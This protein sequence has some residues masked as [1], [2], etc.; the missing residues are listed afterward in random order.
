M[1]RYTKQYCRRDCGPVAVLNVLKWCGE[2]V[3]YKK[4]IKNIKSISDY[5][6]R[7]GVDPPY[8]S[9]AIKQV[10]LSYMRIISPKIADIDRHLENNEAL[11]IRFMYDAHRGHYIFCYSKS[12]KYYRVANYFNNSGELQTSIHRK[13]MVKLLKNYNP[14]KA[15]VWL[16][17]Q[18]TV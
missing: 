5:D 4:H 6:P 13:T 8:I 11:I 9:F 7:C 3:S 18:N 10:G 1:V 17:R 15:L 12:T 2:K 14:H 16:I